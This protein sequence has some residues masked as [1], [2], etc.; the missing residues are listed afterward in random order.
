MLQIDDF[1][2]LFVNV[3]GNNKGYTD[4]HLEKRTEPS[5]EGKQK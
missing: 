5:P 1:P 2:K 4:S 3:Q